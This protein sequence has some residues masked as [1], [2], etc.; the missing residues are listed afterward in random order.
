MDICLVVM[1]GDFVELG[2]HDVDGGVDALC[3]G[4]GV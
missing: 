3:L 2:S 4:V 1:R